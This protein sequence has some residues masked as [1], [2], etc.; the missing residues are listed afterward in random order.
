MFIP[1]EEANDHD[2]AAAVAAAAEAAAQKGQ[3]P[4]APVSDVASRNVKICIGGE[5]ASPFSPNLHG[6][7]G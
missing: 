6:V 7:I 2:T 5:L 3:D 1:R 4:Q